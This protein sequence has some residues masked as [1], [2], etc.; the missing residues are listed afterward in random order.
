MSRQYAD[1]LFDALMALP[2]EAR[3]EELSRRCGDDLPL[4]DEVAAL[5]RAADEGAPERR[6]GDHLDRY[7]LEGRLGRGASGEVW[8][9]FDE[10][11]MAFTALKLFHRRDAGLESV[12]RE[13]RA[14][15]AILS[16]HVVR[17][18]AAGRFEDGTPYIEMP[19]CAE[20]SVDA[21]GQESMKVGRSL[22][23]EAPTDLPEAVRW[24]AEIARGVDAAHR[25][26]VVHRDIKPA[27]VL[28]LPVSRRALV[29]DFGLSSPVLYPPSAGRAPT[30]TMSLALPDRRVVGTPCYM[31]PEV[32]DGL[33]ASR[34]SDIY[35]LGATL[36]ALV[37]GRPPYL[38][39]GEN[40]DATTVLAR[41]AAGPPPP[42]PAPARL[43]RAMA[44]AMARRPRDRYRSALAMAEDLE[45]WLNDYP[46]STDG[47]SRLIA[48]G[49]RLRRHRTLVA[50]A[51][52]LSAL[53]L[54]S[55]AALVHM[56]GV[57]R[58]IAA[59]AELAMARKAAADLEAEAAS[60]QARSSA[61]GA[62]RAALGAAMAARG[63]QEAAASAEDAR[64]E[65]EALAAWTEIEV[66][67][68][69][70]RVEE[71]VAGRID[72]ERRA[73]E[74]EISRVRAD[75]ARA[76]S[77]LERIGLQ[78]R[79]DSVMADLAA[80]RA[81]LA[82]ERIAREGTERRVTALAAELSALQTHLKNLGQAAAPE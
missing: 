25:V 63:A 6:R 65:L 62:D 17:I 16:D 12:L 56:E 20:S 39:E 68:A 59:E 51:G 7:R 61:V 9:A 74:A 5:L 30:S 2:E 70:H 11:L 82:S 21:D 64:K 66:S 43:Q 13:A 38:A 72:A 55:G 58:D 31:A 60:E 36:M 46:M 75:E 49:L 1:E 23:V 42:V 41:V 80:A 32:V 76:R 48:M 10:H 57:R 40:V 34:A 26:G 22:A 27:N 77:E 69:T 18:R 15:S 52:I 4:R 35:A 67:E 8:T 28:L 14:A 73:A 45:A 54:A 37:S 24:V 47:G 19:L 78:R 44:K 3:E 50:T 29:A 53:V 81:D 71:A 79:L 33:G